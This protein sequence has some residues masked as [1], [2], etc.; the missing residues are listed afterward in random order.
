MGR[1]KD[2]ENGQCGILLQGTYPIAGVRPVRPD[3]RDH[4]NLFDEHEVLCEI[5]Y[6]NI[7]LDGAD[8]TDPANRAESSSWGN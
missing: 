5:P 2:A 3:L 6:G 7:Q 1:T 4:H 8:F